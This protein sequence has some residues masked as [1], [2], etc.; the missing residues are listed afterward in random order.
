MIPQ[1]LSVLHTDRT[2]EKSPTRC[3]L[4]ALEVFGTNLDDYLH[5]IIP[6]VVKLFEQVDVS[7][8]VCILIL[9]YYFLSHPISFFKKVRIL[10]IQTLGRLCNKLNF[11]DYSSRIIHPLARALEIV[12]ADLRKE[13]METLCILVYQLGSDYAIFIPMV[14]KV[15]KGEYIFQDDH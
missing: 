7:V 11:S 13:V 3:V 5:L 2:K 8:N 15:R 14:N 9:I 6:A 12:D 4:H 10:A 1:M